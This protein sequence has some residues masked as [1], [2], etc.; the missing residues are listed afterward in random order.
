MLAEAVDLDFLVTRDEIEALE[1]RITTGGGN[2]TVPIAGRPCFN[3]V[4]GC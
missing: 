4:S 3:R 2:S 1:Q